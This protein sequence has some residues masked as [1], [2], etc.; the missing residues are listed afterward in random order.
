MKKSEE[1]FSQTTNLQLKVNNLNLLK[2]IWKFESI[3]NR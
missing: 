2:M 3:K 1:D